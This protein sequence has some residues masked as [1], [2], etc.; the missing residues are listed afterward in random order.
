MARFGRIIAVTAALAAGPLAARAQGAQQALVD[1][2]T[3][4]AQD[5]LNDVNGTDAQRMLRR[6]RAAMICPQVFRAGFLFGG[7]GGDCV[8]VARDGGGSW[9]SPAFYGLGSGSFGFQAGMQDS[10]VM[11]MI[12]T[13]K[14]LRAVMD[15]QFKLGADAGAVFVQWGGGVEGATT[16]GGRRRHRGLHPIAR[17]VCRHLA[18]RQRAVHARAVG[19]GVLRQGGGGA[20]DR[21]LHGRQQ[22]GRRSAARGAEPVRHHASQR[23]PPGARRCGGQRA[24]VAPIAGAVAAARPPGY[25]P[26]QRQAVAAAVARPAILSSGRLPGVRVIAPMAKARAAASCWRRLSISCRIA[27]TSAWRRRGPPWA[28]HRGSVVAGSAA[29]GPAGGGRTA[30]TGSSPAPSSPCSA[31]RLPAC[32]GTGLPMVCSSPCASAPAAARSCSSP[33]RGR[34][35]T[36]CCRLS[37]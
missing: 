6:A 32:P 27:S 1:R 23:P 14:G 11:M 10:E 22:P 33:A 8:L 25:A 5:M 28:R 35:G 17:A 21:H 24:P 15:D 37:P 9:S 13:E 18:V 7:Q 34:T 12:L 20:A 30:R 16:G 26:V 3:L 19:T 31:G 36:N 4:A 29:D 2:S